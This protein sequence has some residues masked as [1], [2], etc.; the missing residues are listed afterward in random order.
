MSNFP[1]YLEKSYSTLG[2]LPPH[3]LCRICIGGAKLH[4]PSAETILHNCPVS[5][6]PRANVLTGRGLPKQKGPSVPQNIIKVCHDV[7][8]LLE[9]RTKNP[10]L[11]KYNKN[12]GA[13]NFF[14]GGGG[15]ENFW[16]GVN[17]KVWFFR[18]KGVFF[19]FGGP[20][21]PPNFEEFWE[22]LGNFGKFRE[23]RGISGNFG[24]NYQILGVFSNF[25]RNRDFLHDF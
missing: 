4:T 2:W 17:L 9:G 22:I 24:E 11:P 8:R 23:F 15:W 7:S 5:P 25:G 20:P 16:G 21:P 1:S 18:K 6:P 3:P 19:E 13:D 10:P 12:V 14:F